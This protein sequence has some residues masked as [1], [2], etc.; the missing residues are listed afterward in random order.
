M[1]TD[2]HGQQLAGMSGGPWRREPGTSAWGSTAVGRPSAP[3]AAAHP[4]PRTTAT[5]C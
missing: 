2:R 4:D 5:S 3:M 1:I